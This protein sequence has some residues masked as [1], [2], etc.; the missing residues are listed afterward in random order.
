MQLS[1]SILNW[2]SP[3]LMA[4]TGHWGSQAPQD[5]HTSEISYA[6]ALSSL[7]YGNSFYKLIVNE[8]GIICKIKLI[9]TKII[10]QNHI[11]S[12]EYS[13]LSLPAPGDFGSIGKDCIPSAIFIDN[14]SLGIYTFGVC[15]RIRFFCCVKSAQ[16]SISAPRLARGQNRAASAFT[17]RAAARQC[18]RQA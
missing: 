11:K 10:F 12:D 8:Q 7:L 16:E 13:I 6:M 1:A 4:L 18:F 2:V 3:A 15:L 5:T 9:L 17:G 14:L